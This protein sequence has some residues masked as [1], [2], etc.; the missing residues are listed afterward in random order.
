MIEFKGEKSFPDEF[1][2]GTA[3]AAFQVEMGRGEVDPN[4]DW[5]V[6]AHDKRNIERGLV[7]GD[8]P[9]NGPGFWELYPNDLRLAREQLGNNAIRLSMDWSRIFP[10]PTTDVPVNAAFDSRGN[11]SGVNVSREI[12]RALEEKANET[13][14][15][16]YR[17]ILEEARRLG[18]TPMLTLYH[19]PL[20]IWIHD[21]IACRDDILHATRRGWVDQTTIIEFAKYAAFVAKTFGDLVDLYATMN[22]P[23]VVSGAGYLSTTTASG[24][25]PGIEDPN[26]FITATKNL[27]MAH[28]IAYEQVKK[29]DKVST[30]KF[31]PAFV[32]LVYDLQYFAPYD[33]KNKDDV[34]AAKF[35]EY[36]WNE[37]FLNAVMK[38]D[39]DINVN[40]AIEKDEQFPH[41]AKGCDY[42][43]VNHY[44][45]A[46]VKF[47]ER[48]K[49]P[50]FNIEMVP[51]Q[52][53]D[54]CTDMG[55]EIY[56]PGIRYA[57]K[58][59]YEK[60]RRPIM[61]TENGIADAKDEKRR[62]YLTQYLQE[63]YKAITE[64][65][66]P[67]K[68]YFHWSLI[69]NYEW[70]NGFKMR[71]GLFKVDYETKKRTP[72]NT[73]PFYREVGTTNS[74]PE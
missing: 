34:N 22:E 33:E 24:F 41:L 72:T 60:Y 18:L 12:M 14:V 53:K 6:W 62:S 48:G 2:W 56:P 13:A 57:V 26:L 70:T 59:C 30:S 23:R 64:D 36:I 44:F 55:W 61:I 73:V 19:W 46:K 35:Y 74:L 3:I 71:F 69:D 4:T 45:R 28:G 5:F 42:I 50:L 21:P 58:W 43:G 27:A 32:G 1:L 51:C 8:L 10:S 25:P 9:E 29:W 20:P 47:V 31:G 52:D 54:K 37:W 7:S 65:G 17:E 66:V 16:K 49:H 63:L 15:R 38:G 11:V 39:Y 40:G 68:G 67:V